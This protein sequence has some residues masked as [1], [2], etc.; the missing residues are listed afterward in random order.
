MKAPTRYAALFVSLLLAGSAAAAQAQADP[1]A[2][3]PGQTPTTTPASQ[4]VPAT[5]TVPAQ[6]GGTIH[7]SVKDGNVPL[8]GVSVTA[9]NSLTGKKYSTTTDITGSYSLEHSAEWPLCAED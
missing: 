8:P 7:G 3:P 4:P 6:T 2:S 9:S 5:S 1:Q